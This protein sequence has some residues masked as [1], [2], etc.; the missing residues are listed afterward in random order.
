MSAVE[1]LTAVYQVTGMS[2]GHCETAVREEV[3]EVPGV[4]QVEVSLESGRL[5]VTGEAVEEAAVIAAVDEAG[6]S[7]ERSG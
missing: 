7:A 3:S 2:C 5:A 1:S 6:Y 4:E